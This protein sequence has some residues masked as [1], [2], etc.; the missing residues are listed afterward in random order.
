MPSDLPVF[1]DDGTL[2]ISTKEAMDI[3]N[4]EALMIGQHEFAPALRAL[5]KEVIRLRGRIKEMH[6]YCGSCFGDYEDE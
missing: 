5:Y 1:D 2:I 4:P 6:Q 3:A